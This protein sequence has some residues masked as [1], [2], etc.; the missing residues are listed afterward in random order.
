VL[1]V[2]IQTFAGLGAAALGLAVGAAL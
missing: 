1:D 2:L